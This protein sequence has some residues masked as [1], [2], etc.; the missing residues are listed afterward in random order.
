MIKNKFLRKCAAASV[1]K[2]LAEDDPRAVHYEDLANY[3]A[4]TVKP[5]TRGHL[6][7]MLDKKKPS[8][9]REWTIASDPI[10]GYNDSDE[11]TMIAH[12]ADL[13]RKIR[14]K[15]LLIA[16]ERA[17]NGKYF[18][19]SVYTGNQI[20]PTAIL[21]DGTKID[22]MFFNSPAMPVSL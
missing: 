8:H 14:D 21:P 2:A 4:S 1:L 15:A 11:W 22:N 3:F 17:K 7:F 12:G 13:M 18:N 10:K 20:K 6:L 16:L 9:M 19:Y 5:G